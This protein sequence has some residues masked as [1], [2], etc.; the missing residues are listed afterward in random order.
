MSGFCPGCRRAIEFCDCGPR[1]AY[2]QA[3]QLAPGCQHQLGC[4]CDT[5]YWLRESTV[6]EDLWAERFIRAVPRL[7][8]ER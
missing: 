1:N 7:S 3:R 8:G 5:P 4:R 2:A 6:A